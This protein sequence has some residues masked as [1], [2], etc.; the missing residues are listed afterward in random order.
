MIFRTGVLII[1]ATTKV[2]IAINITKVDFTSGFCLNN[3]R[4]DGKR[5]IEI[6]DFVHC[7]SVYPFDLDGLNNSNEHRIPPKENIVINIHYYYYEY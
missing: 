6:K 1:I 4:I 3:C 2:T 7:I 5:K